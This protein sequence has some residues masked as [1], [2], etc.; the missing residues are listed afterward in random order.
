MDV[1]DIDGAKAKKVY[2]RQTAYDSFNYTDITKTKFVSS[3]TVN[4]LHPTY[5]VRDQDGQ[6]IEIGGID[7]S[8]PKKLPT[9][10]TGGFFDGLQ[11]ADIPGTAVGSR[12][13]GN[14]HNKERSHFRQ[15]ND[16][17]EIE[18]A[19]VGTLKRGVSTQRRTDPLNPKYNL[20]GAT[21]DEGPY[22]NDGSSLDS[23]YMQIQ[24]SLENRKEAEKQKTL[25]QTV[26][27]EQEFKKDMAK[28]YGVNPGAT[29]E[30][31]LG[32]FVGQIG[33]GA[34]ASQP[35]KENHLPQQSQHRVQSAQVRPQTVPVDLSEKR[36]G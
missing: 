5:Q 26:K 36:S 24:K 30:V 2:V 18:G 14:F 25:K 8:S 19:Q 3:R 32:H 13:V 34:A 35:G 27:N 6:V 23:K 16:I 7:R 28:F 9:R 22:A 1:K 11:I 15:T 31:E 4:P 20:P 33:G 10:T 29:K 21:Q 17:K 12:R